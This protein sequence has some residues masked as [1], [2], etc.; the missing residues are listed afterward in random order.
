MSLHWYQLG[1]VSMPMKK[2]NNRDM[3]A[4]TTNPT[5]LA[6]LLSKKRIKITVSS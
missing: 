3:E 6:L 2:K 5:I 1:A 4:M